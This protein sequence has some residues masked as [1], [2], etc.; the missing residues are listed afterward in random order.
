LW[1]TAGLERF[2][3]VELDFADVESVG[4]GFVDEVFRV[5]STRNP[6]TLLYPV[7]M[8]PAVEFMVTRGLPKRGPY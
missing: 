2:S 8:N 3:E 1:L 7:N 5:W 4:Q 6:D